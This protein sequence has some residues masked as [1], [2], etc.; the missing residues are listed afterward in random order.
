LRIVNGKSRKQKNDMRT[1]ARIIWGLS[2]QQNDTSKSRNKSSKY[3]INSLSIIGVIFGVNLCCSIPC[4]FC[5]LGSDWSS[6]WIIFSER[7]VDRSSNYSGERIN[8]KTF[9]NGTSSNFFVE[10]HA[11]HFNLFIHS[12]YVNIVSYKVLSFI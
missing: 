6:S 4:A 7:L 12:H 5:K 9:V 11:K 8:W 3:S 2:S 1:R 10:L